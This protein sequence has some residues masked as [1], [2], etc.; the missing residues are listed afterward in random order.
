MP[1][2]DSHEAR[3]MAFVRLEKALGVKG[4][5]LIRKK[6]AEL[7]LRL[8]PDKTH[9]FTEKK[10]QQLADLFMFITEF[11]NFAFLR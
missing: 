4:K 5:V 8:H 11:R 1:T 6:V 2:E 10:R 7:C 9:G 3:A